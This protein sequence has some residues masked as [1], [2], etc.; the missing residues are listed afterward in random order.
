MEYTLL[1]LL[2]QLLEADADKPRCPLRGLRVGGAT[3]AHPV[4]SSVLCFLIFDYENQRIYAIIKISAFSV[5]LKIVLCY[6]RIKG[7]RAVL[8]IMRLKN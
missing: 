1:H 4:V 5:F 7:W 6:G 2:I 3:L 8:L